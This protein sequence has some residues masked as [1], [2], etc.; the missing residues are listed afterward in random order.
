[1]ISYFLMAIVQRS[2]LLLVV[3]AGI[4]FS[5]VRWKR[6]PKASLI[7]V[8]ALGFYLFKIFSFM[9]FNYWLPSLRL[10]MQ[11]SYSTA[12][13]FYTVMNVVNEI[14]FA[15]VIVLLVAAAYVD[16]RPVAATSS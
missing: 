1:M 6:H 3:L 4:L 14:G 8:I 13:A 5:I 16:R 11:W 9:I 7:T 2:P 10:S 15:V 12:D